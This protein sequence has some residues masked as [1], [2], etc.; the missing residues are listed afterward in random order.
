MHRNA[1]WKF[2]VT[3][4]FALV[5]AAM[6]AW[7]VAVGVNAMAGEDSHKDQIESYLGTQAEEE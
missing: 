5:M 3:M 4:A 6:G 1:V 7:I 2:M